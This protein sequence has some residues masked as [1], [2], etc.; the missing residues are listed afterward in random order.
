MA[1]EPAPA[2]AAAPKP[3][4]TPALNIRCEGP[5]AKDG[6]HEKLAK[7]FGARNVAPGAAGA[8]VLFP[9]DPKRRLEITWHDAAARQRP[10][11]IAIE[12]A[13]T[14]R[15]RGF[16]VG[17]TLA[18]VEKTNGKPFRLS[19]FIT[20]ETGGAARNW[21]GGTLDKLSGGCQL[22]MRFAPARNA[23]AAARTAVTIE[24]DFVSSSPEIRAVNPVIS[25]LIVGYPE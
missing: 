18:N 10:A 4:A 23:P 24:A 19:G 1:N 13:S 9:N 6:S 17:E 7:S 16:R 20:G 5:F 14:W 2:A 25:E 21:E 3:A 8:T 11:W 12:G 22:G 15:A